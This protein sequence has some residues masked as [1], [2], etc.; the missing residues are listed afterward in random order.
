M[1]QRGGE[2]P[3]G[4]VQGPQGAFSTPST[5]PFSSALLSSRSPPA[6][7]HC[8]CFRCRE[9]QNDGGPRG[10]GQNDR[11]ANQNGR[12]NGYG[13]ANGGGAGGKYQQPWGRGGGGGWGGPRHGYEASGANGT[14]LGTPVRMSPL[15][16]APE[17]PK[18]KAEEKKVEVE[19][20]VE[21]KQENGKEKKGDKKRKSIGGE[22]TAAPEVSRTWLL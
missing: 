8:P 18:A 2:V 17:S 14:P 9:Q 19:K 3:E 5:L 12:Q 1:H 20:V 16:V 11:G 6:F 4:A 13:N 7:P 21:A 15:A 22:D 10:N